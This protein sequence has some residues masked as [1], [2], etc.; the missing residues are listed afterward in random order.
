MPER[1]LLARLLT[2]LVLTLPMLAV[3]QS[4]DASLSAAEQRAQ[5]EAE[6]VFSVIK[7]HTIRSKPAVEPA[8]KPARAPAPAPTAARVAQQPRPAAGP[9]S[10][11]AA[12]AEPAEPN[13]GA[14][15]ASTDAPKPAAAAV[16]SPAP[17]LTAPVEPAVVATPAPETEP[18][19][20]DPEEVPLRLQSFV[21][22]VVTPALQATLGAGERNVRVKLTVETDGRVSQ[23]EAAAGVPRRLARPAVDAILQ[24]RFAP[25]PQAR[26]AEVE[27]AF[28]RD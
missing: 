18:E 22:P 24:W 9:A 26:T 4:S 17:A 14:A 1:P 2:T 16:T 28:R 25:L 27:I 13:A 8:S 10:A 7:F 19:A 11:V 20:D 6:R 5:R 12:V 3:A 15:A 23:A 21:P